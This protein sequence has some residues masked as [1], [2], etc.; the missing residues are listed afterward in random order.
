MADKDIKFNHYDFDQL[1]E[2][3]QIKLNHSVYYDTDNKDNDISDLISKPLDKVQA[4]RD[5]SIVKE[6][7]A[8]EKVRQTAH[9]WEK[10]AAVTARLDK[11]I[12]YLRVPEA[13]HSSNK[14]IDEEYGHKSISNMVYKMRYSIEESYSWRTRKTK[15]QVRWY[16]FLNTPKQHCQMKITGQDKIYPT[17]EE[18]EK[19]MR[20]RIK[21]FS[22]LFN[23]ICPPIPDIYAQHFRVSGQLLRGYTT[24]AMQREKAAAA[25]EKTDGTKKPSVRKQ[26]DTLKGRQQGAA[27]KQPTKSRTQPEIG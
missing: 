21:A 27:V 5:K 18:A 12:E 2:G 6:T 8:Y 19:Y 15:W 13:E 22:H 3:Q 24:E 1:D 20:G 17:K 4:M 11:A 14:W 26:L 7:A 23:E 16:V 9:L 25:P 10:Q